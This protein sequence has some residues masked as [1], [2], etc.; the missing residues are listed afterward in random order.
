MAYSHSEV[1]N[2]IL[3]VNTSS[4]VAN[5]SSLELCLMKIHKKDSFSPVFT[6]WYWN[7]DPFKMDSIVPIFGSHSYYESSKCDSNLSLKV[8]NS[9]K[10]VIIIDL[11]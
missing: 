11:L 10:R 7:V 1:K 8:F 4:S 9:L 2:N 6:L 3:D 5:N